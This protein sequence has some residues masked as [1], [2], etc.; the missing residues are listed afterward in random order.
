MIRGRTP[1]LAKD[2]VGTQICHRK[3]FRRAGNPELL[4][5]FNSFH[6]REKQYKLSQY[7]R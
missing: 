2:Q 5:N 4:V 7:L 3:L 1:G 6:V